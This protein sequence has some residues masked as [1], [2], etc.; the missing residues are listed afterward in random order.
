[1]LDAKLTKTFEQDFEDVT[2]KIFDDLYPLNARRSKLFA[3]RQEKDEW[4]GW[5]AQYAD[6]WDEAGMPTLSM[7]QLKSL[8]AIMLTDNKVIQEE[9]QQDWSA[10][11]TWGGSNPKKKDVKCYH[12]NGCHFVRDCKAV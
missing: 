8:N 4:T 2:A 6:A 5:S 3:M 9:C 10:R 1:M 7:D 11:G 12:C